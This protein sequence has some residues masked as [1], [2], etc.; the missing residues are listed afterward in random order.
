SSR[1]PCDRPI[2]HPDTATTELY[3]LSLHDALPI[4]HA[5][6]SGSTYQICGHVH[7]GVSLRLPTQKFVRLPCF[8]VSPQKIVLPAFSHFTGLDT[9]FQ[10]EETTQYAILENGIIPIK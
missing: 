3:P 7:P 2:L 1:R 4:L 9:R 5:P 6:L 8:V 10:L